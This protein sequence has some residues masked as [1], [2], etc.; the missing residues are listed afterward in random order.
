MSERSD[1]LFPLSQMGNTWTELLALID[2]HIN[3]PREKL[4]QTMASKPDLLT[5][6]SSVSLAAKAKGL[7]DFKEALISEVR[8]SNPST[9]GQG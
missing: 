9:F 5:G 6:K 4:Y 8:L 2:E 3:A 7:E 1:R